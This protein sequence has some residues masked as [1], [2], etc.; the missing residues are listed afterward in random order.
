MG[1]PFGEKDE[2]VTAPLMVT[3]RNARGRAMLDAAVRAGRVEVLQRGG[4]GGRGLP[5]AG[6]R[7]AIT[8]KTVEG[9]SMVKR[10]TQPGY[11]AGDQGAPPWVAD[12]LAT[13]IAKTL[14]KGI[15]FARYSIDYHYLRN[16]LFVEEKLGAKRAAQ[17]VPAYATA[18]MRRYEADM[19]ALRRGKGAAAAGGNSVAAGGPLAQLGGFGAA[20]LDALFVAKPSSK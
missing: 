2:M 19:E 7:R 11:V 18:L 5:S 14:P 10:L 16:Q 15:E 12:V 8:M 13:L 6:Q 9:D 3:V 4:K 17:H 20:F 1:A